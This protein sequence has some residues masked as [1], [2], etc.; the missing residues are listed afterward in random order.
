MDYKDI[1]RII[2]KYAKNNASYNRVEFSNSI[3]STF[4]FN[5]HIEYFSNLVANIIEQNV[6][7]TLALPTGPFC[8]NSEGYLDK[9]F[10]VGKI[11][12]NDKAFMLTAK[13]KDNRVDIKIKNTNYYEIDFTYDSY[14]NNNKC[15]NN[16]YA[17]NWGDGLGLNITISDSCKN[18]IAKYSNFD[19]IRS[20]YNAASSFLNNIL[21]QELVSIVL[22]YS[23]EYYLMCLLE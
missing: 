10:F 19:Y 18:T 9:S 1:T 15:K 6:F 14:F 17:R 5:K 22:N 2:L 4:K 20:Y 16:I 7:V 13:D 11:G 3:R 21:P 8:Y 23:I 12:E